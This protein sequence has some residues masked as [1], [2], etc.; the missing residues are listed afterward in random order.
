[1]S[2][3]DDEFLK[4]LWAFLSAVFVEGISKVFTLLDLLGVVLF[5][6]PQLPE[7]IAN[8]Q[9]TRGIGGAIFMVSFVVAN[10]IVYRKQRQEVRRL[11]SDIQELEMVGAEVW[12]KPV[13]GALE[14]CQSYPTDG[15]KGRLGRHGLQV[16]SGVPGYACLRGSVKY[17]NVG[18]KPGYLVCEIDRQ[19]SELP[20]IFE[21]E[22]CLRKKPTSHL[23]RGRKE[24]LEP[25]IPQKARFELLLVV[26]DRD[27]TDFAKRLGQSARYRIVLKY[28]T[29]SSVREIKRHCGTVSVEGDLTEYRRQVLEIWQ[30]VDRFRYLAEIT[31]N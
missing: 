15:P 25:G 3:Q 8:Q 31:Q 14:F 10:F 28:H 18:E 11:R 16:D 17:G 7:R 9:L 13:N 19:N 6:W 23:L 29:E 26:R 30:R 4:G 1:M 24:R 22:F 27:A 20:S 5:V 21:P 12:F 2:E